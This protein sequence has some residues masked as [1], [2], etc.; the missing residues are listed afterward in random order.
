[1]L[2]CDSLKANTAMEVHNNQ[3]GERIPYVT[4]TP[5]SPVRIE[6]ANPD[7]YRRLMEVSQNT[8]TIPVTLEESVLARTNTNNL[9][10]STRGATG[11]QLQ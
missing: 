3:T 6:C 1:M 10:A 5:R 7:S 8:A 11:D 9:I 4:I 2:R